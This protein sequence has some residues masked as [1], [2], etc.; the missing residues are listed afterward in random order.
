LIED[1]LHA[2]ISADS[3]QF[4]LMIRGRK[5]G[6]TWRP[7]GLEGHR[8]K[9]SDLFINE[10]VPPAAREKWPLVINGE[11]IVWVPGFRPAQA[12]I[13][14]GEQRDVVN[15]RLKKLPS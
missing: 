3:V 6:D 2:W 12:N 8:Q 1:P 4:P 14:T 13:L 10:K 7:L 11:D 15:L 9:I 5:P